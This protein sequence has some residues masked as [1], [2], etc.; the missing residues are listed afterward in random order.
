MSRARR[1][2]AAAIE[3]ALTSIAFFLLLFIIIDYGWLFLRR[4]NIQDAV[5][6]GARAGSV[7]AT[8]ADPVGTATAEVQNQLV[9]H[10][11]DP[12]DVA[13]T[14]AVGGSTPT[15]VLTVSADM[16]YVPPV[17]FSVLPVPDR[18]GATMSMHLEVQ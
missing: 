2:G 11:I 15:Q 1:R 3:F 9:A 5:F 16:P 13:I 4:A 6:R 10:G 14:A 8:S 18:I 7:V 12:A 17:N